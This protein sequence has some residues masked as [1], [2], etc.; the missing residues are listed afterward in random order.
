[1]ATI[2]RR[3]AFVFFVLGLAVRGHATII[4]NDT[5]SDDTRT[6]PA[7]PV[8]SEDG[9]DTDGDGDIESAWFS[10]SSSALTVAAPGDL[11]AVQPTTSLSLN[12]SDRVELNFASCS[13]GL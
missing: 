2:L 13:G 3:I 11:R 1:M 12:N 7:A 10:S 4:V 5:W 8:Y 6:D 9:T